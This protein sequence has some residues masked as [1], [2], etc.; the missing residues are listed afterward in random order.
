[1]V[2]RSAEVALRVNGRD[3]TVVAEGD[4][5]LLYLLRN[6]EARAQLIADPA[7]AARAEARWPALRNQIER[8]F[9]D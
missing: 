6:D 1:M 2:R 3:A 7:I 8:D 9:P 5:P 4:T